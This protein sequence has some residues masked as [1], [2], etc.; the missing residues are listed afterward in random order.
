MPRRH[1]TV[2]EVDRL[3]P[4]LEQVFIQVLQLRACLSREEQK[5]A[6][7]GVRMT[8]VS[9]ESTDARDSGQ[10]RQAKLMFRGFWDALT[11]KLREVEV[12]GGEVK[13]LDTGLVDFRGKRGKQDVCLCWKFGEKNVSHWHTVDSG[14]AGRRPLHELFANE[15]SVTD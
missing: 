5:L 9:L 15:P 8:A 14:Y 3:I 13:D 2:P 10:V 6:S 4:S 7:A 1:F 11:E 12:L